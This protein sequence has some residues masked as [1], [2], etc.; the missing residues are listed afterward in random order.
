M[1]NLKIFAYM[2]EKY[3]IQQFFFVF[4]LSTANFALR[5][6]VP[7]VP[8]FKIRYVYTLRYVKKE[9]RENKISRWCTRTSRGSPNKEK[10]RIANFGVRITQ[11]QPL[12]L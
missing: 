4:L 7:K 11:T 9:M 12:T 3:S 6:G 8:K 1:E 2:K 5:I 10:K